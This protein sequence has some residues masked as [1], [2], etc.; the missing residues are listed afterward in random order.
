MRNSTIKNNYTVILGVLFWICIWWII[1]IIVSNVDILPSPYETIKT[2]SKLVFEVKFIK[3]IL[4][5]LYRVF[6]GFLLSVI[7]GIGIGVICGLNKML[8]DL[9]NP[10]IVTVKSTPV[11]SIIFIVGLWAQSGNVPI[12]ISF[13]MSFPMIWTNTVEG[14]KSTDKKLLEMAKCYNVRRT[15]IVKNIYLPSIKPFIVSGITF[16]VGISWKVTVAAEALSHPRFAIGARLYDSK[17]YFDISEV[18]AWTFIV[19]ML[20]FMFEYGIKYWLKKLN[21]NKGILDD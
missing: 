1:S 4:F 14:I 21:T 18:F 12:V 20:S 3:S 15:S 2:L 11:I 5:T 10:L 9:I 16:A 8:Y 17:I 19:V 13:L 6:F 7:I